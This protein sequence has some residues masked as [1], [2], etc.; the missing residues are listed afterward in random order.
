MYRGARAWAAGGQ[1]APDRDSKR[2]SRTVR[3]GSGTTW[4]SLGTATLLDTSTGRF[5]LAR[6]CR[7]SAA[8]FRTA[9]SAALMTRLQAAAADKERLEAAAAAAAASADEAREDVD[10]Q[11]LNELDSPRDIVRFRPITPARVAALLPGA[12]V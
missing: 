4:R 1:A 5:L 10:R 9:R 11:V 3:L 6:A 2:G 8:A 7:T 12:A